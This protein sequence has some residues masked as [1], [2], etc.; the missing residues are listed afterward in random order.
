MQRVLTDGFYHPELRYGA[1]ID[2]QC[3]LALR[4]DKA[5]APLKLSA[6]DNKNL[7]AASDRAMS[8]EGHFQP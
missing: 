3:V 4:F 2:D 7:V 6:D 1:T 5:P 8:I